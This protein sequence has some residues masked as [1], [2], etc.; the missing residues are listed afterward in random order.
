MASVKKIATVVA[1]L[2]EAFNRKPTTA[3]FKAY[4]VGL[5][6]VSD[7]QLN[8]AANAVL[9]DTAEFMPTPG[10]LRALALTRGVGYESRADAAWMLLC[11]AIQKFGG[12]RSVNFRDGVVNAVVRFLGG[13]EFVCQR[14]IEEFEKWTKRDF[15]A[16]YTRFMQ[17]GC[18]P[19]TTGY[20]IGSNEKA[21]A[22]WIGR[23]YGSGGKPYELPAP[24][25]VGC[26]YEPLV[27]SAPKQQPV[28]NQW[29]R[30]VPRL[31][32]KSTP[33]ITISET[34]PV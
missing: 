23:E 13:W 14:P 28:L 27:L 19:Q 34:Q 16:A 4:E 11:K 9:A 21:N 8:T 18:P 33:T 22:G 20:L 7:E 12:G 32:L 26:D 17:Y 6:D 25:D 31:E 30:D 1:M 2:C 5:S 29:P 10:Q 15:L 3:T 24:E